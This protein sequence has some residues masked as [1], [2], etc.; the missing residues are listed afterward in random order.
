MRV[1]AATSYQ[2]KKP[3]QRTTSVYS[4]KALLRSVQKGQME[5]SSLLWEGRTKGMKDALT[6]WKVTSHCLHSE[7]LSLL[8]SVAQSNDKEM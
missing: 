8:Q 6:T 5:E 7:N 3:T 1:A 4:A 2:K